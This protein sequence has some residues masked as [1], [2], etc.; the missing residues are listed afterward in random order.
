ML[1]LA[2]FNVFTIDLT[3]YQPNLTGALG[4]LRGAPAAFLLGG[5]AALLAGACVAPV[6]IS[7]LVIAGNLYKAGHAVGLLLPFLLGIG[8]AL[9]W[10]LAGAGLAVLP[11][12]GKWMTRVKQAF[13]VFIFLFALYYAHV[14]YSLYGDRIGGGEAAHVASAQ[15]QRIEK[16][17]WL[18]SLPE[19]LRR[20][21]AE[22][23]PL[24]IDFWASWCKSCLTMDETTFRDP[25]VRARL[26]S[27]VKVKYR[28]ED[29]AASPAR[30]VL[31]Y[32]GVLGL[33]TYVVVRPQG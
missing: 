14:G 18:T 7:V 32:F 1:A 6:V 15:A 33:P 20:A 4:R 29:P 8:M 11:K 24:F 23:R 16:E 5:V 17:G 9:P 22:G 12:P 2:M 13:G 26:G 28:A 19:A 31:A 3:R 10:P 21:K 30:E 27:F 25:E